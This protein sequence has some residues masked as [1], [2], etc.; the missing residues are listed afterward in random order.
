MDSMRSLMGQILV[1]TH[2]TS[3]FCRSARCRDVHKSLQG[4][5]AKTVLRG[6]SP[7]RGVHVING[8]GRWLKPKLL[9]KTGKN[10]ML[11]FGTN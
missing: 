8:S 6:K 5:A 2:F 9:L 10:P 3:R 1:F 7:R 11:K 4:L